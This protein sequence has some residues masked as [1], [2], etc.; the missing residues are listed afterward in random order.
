MGTVYVLCE[1]F[2]QELLLVYSFGVHRLYRRLVS[3]HYLFFTAGCA[4]CAPIAYSLYE[5]V[6]FATAFNATA[7]CAASAALAFGVFFACRLAR[8]SPG[9]LGSIREAEAELYEARSSRR[10][11]KVGTATA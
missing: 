7:G 4:L 5:A 3:L 1:Q 6:G 8:A 2:L 10:A 9:V 11:G